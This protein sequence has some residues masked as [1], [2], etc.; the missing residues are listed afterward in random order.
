M[1]TGKRAPG[2]RPALAAGFFFK[3]VLPRLFP[4]SRTARGPPLSEKSLKNLTVWTLWSLTLEHMFH[5]I[6]AARLPKELSCTPPLSPSGRNSAQVMPDE[7]RSH[8]G[9]LEDGPPALGEICARSL[10]RSRRPHGRI[11]LSVAC[12]ADEEDGSEPA[13]AAAAVEEAGGGRRPGAGWR[14]S[15]RNPPLAHP[16]GL[17]W[18]GGWGGGRIWCTPHASTRGEA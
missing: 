1:A 7:H 15:A 11:V 17:G 2:C 10:R 12:H 18:P 13:L 5:T 6:L 14:R 16:A 9:R 3:L 4:S 8:P